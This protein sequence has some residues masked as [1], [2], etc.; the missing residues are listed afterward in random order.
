MKKTKIIVP[1]LGLLLL[2]TAAS[3]SG[4]VAWF[5]AQRTFSHVTDQFE[6]KKL[7]GA[8][9]CTVTAG[10]GTYVATSTTTVL[11]KE[12]AEGDVTSL[13]DASFDHG[14]TPTLY[15]DNEDNTDEAT[16]IANPGADGNAYKAVD[17]LANA[18]STHSKWLATGHIYY[19]FTWNLEFSYTFGSDT[20]SVNVFFNPTTAASF[21]TRTQVTAGTGESTTAFRIAF[22]ASSGEK[23]VWAPN[24]TCNYYTTGVDTRSEYAASGILM[25]STYCAGAT[26]VASGTANATQ[27]A[28][29]EYLGTIA[30]GGSN[31]TVKCIAWYEGNDP[32][33]VNGVSMDKVAATM[34]FYSRTVGA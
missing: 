19:A 22:I 20:S 5:T 15:T 33:L 13:T 7:D 21:L 28:K 25:N 8:L 17:T 12:S 23:C 18:E 24:S 1:A 29:T 26:L 11:A 4:T 9:A 32:A 6:V 10:V 14:T 27:I 34:A 16:G 31:L 2:S 3:I 30:S